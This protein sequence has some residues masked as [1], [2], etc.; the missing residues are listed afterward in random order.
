M[1]KLFSLTIM[2]VTLCMNAQDY[3]HISNPV[4]DV[5]IFEGLDALGPDNAITVP[6]GYFLTFSKRY[7]NLVRGS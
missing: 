3:S 7:M 1:K 6:D 2:L 4:V 5:V